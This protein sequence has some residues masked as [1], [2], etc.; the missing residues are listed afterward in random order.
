MSLTTRAI[1]AILLMIGFYVLS[2][3]VAF[4][5]IWIPYAEWSYLHRLDIRIAAACI[6]GAG[7]ILW[8]ILPRR[9]KFEAPGP[10]VTREQ[11][12]RLF[13]ELEDIARRTGQ[14]LPH[15]VYF[16]PDVNAWVAQRGGTMGFGS[17]RVM[18][19]GL[20]LMRLLTVSQFRAVLAHEFG[21]YCGGDTA[22]GPWIY[23][24]RSAIVRTLNQLAQAGSYVVYLF[25]WYAKFFMR[26]TLAISRSQEYAADRLGAQVAGGRAMIEGLKQVHIGGNAWSTYLQSEVRPVIN[27]GFSPP[28]S[29]GFHSFLE[30]PKI[31]Q[32]SEEGLAQELATGKAQPYNSHP[33]LPE[34][35]AALQ[36]LPLG[37]AS[38]DRLATDLL[39]NYDAADTSLFLT[40]PGHTLKP[41]AWEDALPQVYIASWRKTVQS[42]ADALR[43]LTAASLGKELYSWEL[44]NHLK[45]PGMAPSND[46]RDSV[47]IPLAGCALAIALMREG[48]TP[49][50]APGEAITFSKN[51]RTISPFELMYQVSRAEMKPEQWLE[52]CEEYGITNLVVDPA[53]TLAAANA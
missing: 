11:Q 29:Q 38:D 15:E 7:V 21:H 53:V 33:A 6:I 40:N 16:I 45:F 32:A 4:G 35:I 36:S 51:D 18:G 27:A 52:R 26:I 14:T 13:A 47:A 31:K 39:D 28:L 3:V 46:Q 25:N 20:P 2:I 8:S 24:T 23:K 19:L 43:K 17:R 1:I 22:L 10:R 30:S 41:I 44:R 12:P 50:S 5:L 9:D 34:R 49:Y 48:W 37:A 42:Q